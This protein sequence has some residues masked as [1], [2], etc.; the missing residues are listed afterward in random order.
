[1]KKCLFFIVLFLRI[2]CQASDFYEGYVQTGSQRFPISFSKGPISS[3]A[4]VDYFAGRRVL[5][6]E[7]P[8]IGT[9]IIDQTDPRDPIIYSAIFMSGKRLLVGT[10]SS[11]L[12]KLFADK[13]SMLT[14]YFN[15][16]SVNVML[17]DRQFIY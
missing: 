7:S 9:V 13:P 12:Q 14:Y 11:D 4:M 2:N 1:M 5:Y 15:G 6:F 16:Q 3:A 8:G 10:K 17:E